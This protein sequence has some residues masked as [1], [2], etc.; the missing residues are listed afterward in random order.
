MSTNT[1][2]LYRGASH[3]ELQH[4][5]SHTRQ[6]AVLLS[7]GKVRRPGCA[8]VAIATW[9]NTRA[10]VIRPHHLGMTSLY[11]W[12]SAH[13]HDMHTHSIVHNSHTHTHAL[14][15][16]RLA[17]PSTCLALF[18]HGHYWSTPQ[19]TMTQRNMRIAHTLMTTLCKQ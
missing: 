17:N 8:V 5:H 7:P 18:P 2:G 9:V 15:S 12:F 16:C 1:Q 19:C 11:C 3:M 10:I 6:S 13:I 14:V 4:G